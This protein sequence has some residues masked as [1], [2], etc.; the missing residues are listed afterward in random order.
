MAN[1]QPLA[2][3]ANSQEFLDQDTFG[4]HVSMYPSVVESALPRVNSEMFPTVKRFEEV[5][6][7]TG[8]NREMYPSL[9]LIDSYKILED[10]KKL[11]NNNLKLASILA[12][13]FEMITTAFI[14]TD[15]I[16]DNQDLRWK[17]LSWY[18]KPNI[19]LTAIVDI[20]HIRA[21]AY[22]VLRKYFKDHPSYQSLMNLIAETCFQ[23]A[24]G[25]S[26]DVN[27]A[28]S[29]RETRDINLISMERYLKIVKYKS[30]IIMYKNPP[31]AAMHLAEY[32]NIEL[33]QNCEDIFE[34]LSTFRQ[35]QNDVWDCFGKYDNLGKTGTDISEGKCTWTSATALQYATKRQRQIFQDNYGKIDLDSQRRILELYKEIDVVQK[36]I[37]YKKELIGLVNERMDEIS[38]ANLRKLMNLFID[39]YVDI[40]EDFTV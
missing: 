23:T 31:L 4:M 3:P 35:A 33:L 22:T 29:F 15:D 7:Y 21:S 40:D 20:D 6:Y 14:M 18:K 39:I 13:C 2:E 10:P 9:I 16:L 11:T 30:G 8:P 26:F 37:D 27:T 36:F 25:Q 17:K 5:C 34:K 1:S 12:W 28:N 24:L 38:N 19:G 32:N